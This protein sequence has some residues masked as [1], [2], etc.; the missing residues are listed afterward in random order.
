MKTIY[1]PKLKK[2]DHIRVIAPARSLSLLTKD[3]INKAIKRLEKF[4]F[5][6]S[7]GKHVYEIDDFLSSS[8]ESR[9]EDLHDAFKD[10]NVNWILS[11]VWGYN[12]N[13][14]LDY[15]DYQLIKDNP[16]ILCGFSDIT[17]LSNA[18]FTKTGVVWYSGPH[19][20][21]WGIKYWFDFSIDYF[22]KCC[23]K[24]K[25]YELKPT[26]KRS[27][28]EWYLDQEKRNFI[29]NDGYWILN[30]WNAKWRLIGWHLP[31]IN[32]LQWTNYWG[33]HEKESIYFIEIDEEFDPVLFDR[34]IQALIQQNSFENIKWLVIW[35][36]QIK[37]NMTKKLLKKIIKS[38][39]ELNYI[40]IIA[41][42]DFGHT[43]PFITYPIWWEVEIVANKKNSTI[44]I[45]NH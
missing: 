13:Q 9:I 30:E 36:F 14:L 33:K 26:E 23:I 7:F 21:S 17:A 5:T 42:V 1:P 18:I 29:E 2:W 16:K 6:V 31:C 43:M 41:N 25:P 8:I 3:A 40:P 15:I 28:D 20:S 37:N 39:K 44:N 19:F 10:T 27:D 45:F 22:E 35:R 38:K 4:W 11:V 24:N 32:S 34:W 12:S